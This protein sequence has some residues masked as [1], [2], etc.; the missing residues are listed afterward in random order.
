MKRLLPLLPLL[1]LPA[2]ALADGPRSISISSVTRSG[3]E[4]SSVEL[5]FGAGRA[6]WTFDLV[7]MSGASDGGDALSAWDR[8]QVVAEIGDSDSAYTW[9]APA[10][11]WDDASNLRFALVPKSGMP[12]DSRLESVTMSHLVGFY[13]LTDL[14]CNAKSEVWRLETDSSFPYSKS[15]EAW[16]GAN[17]YLQLNVDLLSS[18]ADRSHVV[19]AYN[20]DGDNKLHAWQNGNLISG[21]ERDWKNTS[22]PSNVPIGI[23]ALGKSPGDAKW[24]CGGTLWTY[25][26]YKNGELVGDF[27][28]VLA[29]SVPRLFDRIS[30]TI[31]RTGHFDT[32]PD[33]RGPVVPEPP[34]ATSALLQVVHSAAPVFGG[35]PSVT[36]ILG[37]SATFAGSLVSF[38]GDAADCALS[39]LV[40]TQPDLSDAVALATGA[41]DAENGAFAIPV[42]GLAPETVYYAAVEATG[43]AGGTSRSDV[44]SFATLGAWTIDAASFTTFQRTASFTVTPVRGAGDATFTLLVTS[45]ESAKTSVVRSVG[46]AF[47]LV[48]DSGDDEDILW[49]TP[50]EWRLRVESECGGASWSRTYTWTDF[51][52]GYLTFRDTALY[53][54]TG[55]G[56]T[57]AWRDAG[58][59][60]LL[61]PATAGKGFPSYVDNEWAGAV[62]TNGTVAEVA[63]DAAGLGVWPLRV[64]GNAAV[65]LR[66]GAEG[67][68]LGVGDFA[69]GSQTGD[70]LGGVLTIDGLR[71][72]F[73]R[74]VPVGNGNALVLDNGANVTM[75]CRD[76]G[77]ALWIAAQYTTFGGYCGRV[78]VRGGSSLET[79]TESGIALGADGL[80]LVSNATVRAS[81]YLHPNAY[82][83][84]GRVRLEGDSP[85]LVVSGVLRGWN[86]SFAGETN[87]VLEFCVPRRGWAT[88]PLCFAEDTRNRYAVPLGGTSDAGVRYG[89]PN[90]LPI[91]LRIAADSPALEYGRT[92]TALVSWAPGVNPARVLLDAMPKPTKD[93]WLSAA[94]SDAPWTWNEVS[95]WTASTPMPLAM[96]ARLVGTGGTLILVR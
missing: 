88:A 32:Y 55:G 76:G 17:Y 40:G 47:T 51:D 91:R 95:G 63:L 20:E 85:S 31:Y 86:Q 49:D 3:E 52:K 92:E 14:R 8:T 65:T 64:E 42:A 70:P 53:V 87:G 6:G 28:P 33:E 41:P 45:A 43:G 50:Y 15:G 21:A 54:W 22:T 57:A 82:T 30:G 36:A 12:Y 38:G 96:G 60:E 23:W 56:E 61:P 77:A 7:A 71:A 69:F 79:T 89:G 34:D 37:D 83:L 11:F 74:N 10:G 5:A 62:F 19:I 73:F 90:A 18:P 4:I 26:I 72:N 93:L 24:G 44:V 35:V 68:S 84:G 67:A 27:V 48:W 29:G 25:K 58:N 16:I 81:T 80:L 46:D 75:N 94:S 66:P 13:I 9:T 39:L 78:E 1:L 2:L 59:W